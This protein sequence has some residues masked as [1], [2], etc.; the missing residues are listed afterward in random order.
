MLLP[1]FR[2][3]GGY[4]GS[5]ATVIDK[6]GPGQGGQGGLGKATKVK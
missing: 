6:V 2:E 3:K 4:L 5:V 1:T